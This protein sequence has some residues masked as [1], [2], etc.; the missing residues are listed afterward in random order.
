[1]RRSIVRLTSFLAGI[2]MLAACGGTGGNAGSSPAPTGKPSPASLSVGVVGVIDVAPLFLGIQKG[3]FAKQ[4]LTITPK[5]LNTGATVVAGVVAG[6]LQLGFSNITSIVIAASNRFPVHIVAAGNQAAGGDYSA[7][8]VRNDS[9]ITSAKDLVGKKIAVNGLKNIG[10]LC[11]NA[12]LQASKVD[13][14][15]IQY[16]EVPFPQMGA[17]LAQGT[18]DAVWTVEPWSTVV[19]AGGTNR[20]VLRPF[21][22]IA[23]NFPIASYFTST[24]YMQGNP[25]VVKRF[26]TAVNQS[27]TYAQG[28][29]AEVRAVLPTYIKLAPGLQEQVLLPF[30]HTDL[31]A[32]LIQKTA[33]LAVQY[34][35]TTRKP[36]MKQLLA[37]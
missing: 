13:I 25:G 4:Q 26:R 16:V 12:A 23:K 2:A 30:W 10:S 36:D 18:V 17:A 15:G 29:P 9:S 31:E 37:S 34:G 27:L 20:V 19:K 3:F 32:N 33:D 5:V 35:Y 28:H 8:Y 11:V 14:S 6:D 7:V 21:T 24:Q 1:M 22:L